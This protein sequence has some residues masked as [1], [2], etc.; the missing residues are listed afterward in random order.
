MKNYIFYSCD[1]HKSNTSRDAKFTFT[2]AKTKKV[3]QF[4]ESNLSDYFDGDN[5]YKKQQLN[6]F[7]ALVTYK[8][9]IAEAINTDTHLYAC[10]EEI[11]PI[12]EL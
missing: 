4:I 3:L 6:A 11:K 10:C 5:T 8:G 2:E 7:S 9:S 1:Q 12:Q